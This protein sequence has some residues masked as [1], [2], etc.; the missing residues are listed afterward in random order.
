MTDE[1]ERVWE[2]SGRG[3]I[4]DS[5]SAF[6]WRTEENCEKCQSVCSRIMIEIQTGHFPALPLEFT[7]LGKCSGDQ[8]VHLCNPF[9][10][11]LCRT[12]GVKYV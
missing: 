2:G 9:Q 1:S 8:R 5:I 7:M 3:H 6:A 12:R 4:S 11:V 10:R